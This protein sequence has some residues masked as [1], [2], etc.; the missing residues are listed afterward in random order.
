MVWSGIGITGWM[1]VAFL[2]QVWDCIVGEWSL[3]YRWPQES[4]KH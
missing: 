2:C 3:R 1:P 4:V